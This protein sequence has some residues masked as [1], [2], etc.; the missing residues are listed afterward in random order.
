MAT[1][2]KDTAFIVSKHGSPL[3]QLTS[4]T[5]PG[6]IKYMKDGVTTDCFSAA[7]VAAS[8]VGVTGIVIPLH[9]DQV[10][11]LWGNTNINVV[12]DPAE[13]NYSLSSGDLFS[14][15]VGA[16]GNAEKNG[17]AQKFVNAVLDGAYRAY[18]SGVDQTS[19]LSS[20]TVTRG[21]LSLSNTSVNDGTGIVNTYSRSY[22]VNFKYFQSGTINMSGNLDPA[23]PD[24][25]DDNSDGAP[26]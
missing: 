11:D 18:Q 21:D 1:I 2:S 23:K 24:I 20:M 10:G 13:A 6:K 22:S 8:K 16:N 5:G 19:G 15:G 25:A 12:G 26:F 17:G 14:D 7:N 9:G 4:G 3:S